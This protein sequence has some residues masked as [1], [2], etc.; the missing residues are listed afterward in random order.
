MPIYICRI[1]LLSKFKQFK[2][3]KDDFLMGIP[4][5]P[6]NKEEPWNHKQ[7]CNQHK[8]Y[9]IHSLLEK[10]CSSQNVK[11]TKLPKY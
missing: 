7:G 9:S 2:V 6:K 4:K 10:N 1:D 8:Y 5:N 3:N 11:S